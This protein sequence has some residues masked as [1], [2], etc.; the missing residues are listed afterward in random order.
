[1]IWRYRISPRYREKSN[2][3][4][5]KFNR[6]LPNVLASSEIEKQTHEEIVLIYVV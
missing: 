4:L 2:Q 3:I 1:M 5:V 6:Y